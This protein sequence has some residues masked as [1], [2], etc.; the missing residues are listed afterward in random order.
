MHPQT[1]S[2][3]QKGPVERGHVK[4]R[5]KSSKSVKNN[6]DNFRAA[7]FF[8][9]LL[10]GSETKLSTEACNEQTHTTA[11]LEC[12]AWTLFGS[13]PAMLCSGKAVQAACEKVRHFAGW[14]LL[15]TLNSEGEK[16]HKSK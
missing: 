16:R 8:R 13:V 15:K 10:G 2:G 6:F 4:K 12:Q 3:L 9:P 7:P 1:I 14:S 5:Q 11:P